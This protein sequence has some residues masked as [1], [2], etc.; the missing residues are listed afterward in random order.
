MGPSSPLY[1]MN[2]KD[3]KF[4]DVIH[5]VTRLL[6]Q[7]FD[8]LIRFLQCIVRFILRLPQTIKNIDFER[9]GQVLVSAGQHLSQFFIDHERAIAVV[10]FILSNGLLHCVALRN[11]NGT[12]REGLL[13]TAHQTSRTYGAVHTRYYPSPNDRYQPRVT[14]PLALFG[15]LLMIASVALFIDSLHE[16]SGSLSF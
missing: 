12:Q 9:L 14:N 11:S 13:M 5:A 7:A 15:W 16:T 8:E 6:Q 3:D 10:L 2:H 1:V 4:D